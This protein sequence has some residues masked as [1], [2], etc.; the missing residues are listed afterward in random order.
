M[1]EIVMKIFILDQKKITW[2]DAA[3]EIA[4]LY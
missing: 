2:E 4:I 3:W 1:E